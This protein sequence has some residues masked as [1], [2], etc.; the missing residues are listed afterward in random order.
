[1]RFIT[2][3]HVR[4]TELNM[5][6][7]D[8]HYGEDAL[9]RRDAFSWFNFLRHHN[10]GADRDFQEAVAEPVLRRIQAYLC[11]AFLLLCGEQRLLG[12]RHLLPGGFEI[13][14]GDVA[15][16]VGQIL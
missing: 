6:L 5:D 8:V 3:E 12:C 2:E 11:G 15:E 13:G 16:A 10:R 1:M 7:S 14:G 4:H 9:I